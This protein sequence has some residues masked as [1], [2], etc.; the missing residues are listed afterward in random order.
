MVKSLKAFQEDMGIIQKYI[1]LP[2]FDTY[3]DKRSSSETNK[4]LDKIQFLREKN[5]PLPTLIISWVI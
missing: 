4:E 3:F 1:D 2:H 5:A